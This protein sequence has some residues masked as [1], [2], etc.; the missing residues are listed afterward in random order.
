MRRSRSGLLCFWLVTL[1]ACASGT[2]GAAGGSATGDLVT[3]RDLKGTTWT[4][5]YEVLQNNDNLRV[6]DQA[7]FLRTRSPLTIY[8]HSSQEGM[9][10][11]LDGTEIRSG[12]PDILRGIQA[13]NI[14]RIRIL[15]PDQAGRFGTDGGNGV[16]I[17][18]TGN[19]G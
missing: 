8:G 13:D 6:T 16:L 3:A 14:V 2:G 18:Q 19:G 5:A 11:V 10:L 4:T 17:I 12:V 15:N 9:L 1:A 7:V